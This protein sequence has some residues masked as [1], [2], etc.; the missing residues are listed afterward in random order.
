MS[1]EELVQN[2][3]ASWIHAA[4]LIEAD[5]LAERKAA[6]ERLLTW[7]KSVG[8]LNPNQK[9]DLTFMAAIEREIMDGAGGEF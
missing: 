6:V 9:D 2:I 7:G 8:W 1:A 4:A 5:R 3:R